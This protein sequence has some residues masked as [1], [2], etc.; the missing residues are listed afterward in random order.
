MLDRA[1]RVERVL[2]GCAFGV[3]NGPVQGTVNGGRGRLSHGLAHVAIIQLH[4]SARGMRFHPIRPKRP[5]SRGR[6]AHLQVVAWPVR[7][8][9]SR[10]LP[11]DEPVLVATAAGHRLSSTNLSPQIVMISPPA[12]DPAA[13]LYPCVDWLV[14]AGSYPS[15]LASC[16]SAV[17]LRNCGGGVVVSSFEGGARI[18]KVGGG[19]GGARNDKMYLRRSGQLRRAKDERI[20]GA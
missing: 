17:L 6:E 9:V 2:E 13:A 16:G 1:A 8:C 12:T 14:S 18:G 10:M 15:A 3:L 5:A 20:L 11:Y 4:N 19:W 7:L